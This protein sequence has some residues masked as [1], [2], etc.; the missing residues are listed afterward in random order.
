VLSS[1]EALHTLA[2]GAEHVHRDDIV[3]ATRVDAFD[4]VMEVHR[5]SRRLVL[6]PDHRWGTSGGYP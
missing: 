1:E 3:L 6:R 5:E 4:F 2:L